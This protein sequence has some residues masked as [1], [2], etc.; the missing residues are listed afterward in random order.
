MYLLSAEELIMIRREIFT[1]DMTGKILLPEDT[2]YHAGDDT[3]TL[4][5]MGAITKPI[6][7]ELSELE[8]TC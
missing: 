6:T 2:I 3:I 4:Y 5:H 8:E 7:R 1:D